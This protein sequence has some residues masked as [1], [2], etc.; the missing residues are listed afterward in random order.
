MADKL[1]DEYVFSGNDFDEV[2]PELLDIEKEAEPALEQPNYAVPSENKLIRNVLIVVAAFLLFLVVYK[3]V[4]SF[5]LEKPGVV[6]IPPVTPSQ[7][8]IKPIVS[9]PIP[10]NNVPEVVVSPT[11][12]NAENLKKIDQKLIDLEANQHNLSNGLNSNS[13]QLTSIHS[14]TSDLNDKIMMLNSALAVLSTKLEDQSSQISA[15]IEKQKTT[16]LKPQV[17]NR[18]KIRAAVFFHIQAVIPGRAWLI[19][20]NGTTLT[21]REGSKVPGYGVVK[22]IDAEQGRLLMSSGK[23]IKFSESDS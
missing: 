23:T 22:L 18:K 3:F 15:L 17:K 13:A 6:Q 5:L 7:A 21:V 1:D 19:A 20:T 8:I 14:S 16:S 11:T 9:Q 12:K 4:H 10:H 2:S